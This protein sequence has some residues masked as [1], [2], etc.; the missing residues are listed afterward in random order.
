[1]YSTLVFC[2]LLSCVHSQ[3]TDSMLTAVLVKRADI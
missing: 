3:F 1:M 2:S